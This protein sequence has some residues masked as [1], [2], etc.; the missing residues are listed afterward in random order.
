MCVF[1]DNR[2]YFEPFTVGVIAKTDLKAEKDIAKVY[3][4]MDR[5]KL[6]FYVFTTVYRSDPPNS[7]H[8]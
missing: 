7:R 4:R 2:S 8:G 5:S 3:F 6:S 1:D